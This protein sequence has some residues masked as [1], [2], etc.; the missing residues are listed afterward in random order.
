ME[1]D[2]WDHLDFERDDH[3]EEFCRERL[4]RVRIICDGDQ[5]GADS[6]VSLYNIGKSKCIKSRR[7][8]SGRTDSG[9]TD[10]GNTDSGWTSS[11]RT[12]PV[13]PIQEGPI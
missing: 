1:D 8:D 12:I 5:D 2:D 10:S 6:M 7:N 4:N 11:G 13:G 3:L 9:R